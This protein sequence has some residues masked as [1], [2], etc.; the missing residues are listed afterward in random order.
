KKLAVAVVTRGNVFIAEA[1]ASLPLSELRTM[2]PEEYEKAR[3]TTT[4]PFNYDVVV[5]DGYLPVMPAGGPTDAAS[6]LP[7]GRFLVLGAVPTGP[8]GLDDKGKQDSPSVILDW[9]RDHPAL[10]NLSLDALHIARPRNVDIPKGAAA[11]VLANADN[12]PAIVELSSGSSR[13]IDVTF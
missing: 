3:A 12:G 2:T 13:L 1:L 6:P 9:S 11:V 10:R 8:G 7:P 5:L 4:P